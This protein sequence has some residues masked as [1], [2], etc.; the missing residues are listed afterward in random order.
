MRLY[1][2]VRAS[3]A[4]V[5]TREA[6]VHFLNDSVR[7]ICIDRPLNQE[8]LE[9]AKKAEVLFAENIIAQDAL[10][11][12]VHATNTTKTISFQ[13]IKEIVSGKKNT[14]KSVSG[15]GW[16]GAIELALTGRNSGMYEL[17]QR[18]F[19]QLPNELAVTSLGRTQQDVTA[20][21]SSHPQAIG[22]V[23]IA[24]LRNNPV[25]VKVLAVE[26]TN[27]TD[28]RYVKPNQINIYR[29]LYP[30]CYSLYLYTFASSTA[31]PAGFS[32]FVR[33]MHGQKIIQNAG[34][35]PVVIPNRVIQITT[36]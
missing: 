22:I 26:S 12:L 28:E 9:V 11:V 21:V 17:L 25:S 31:V 18:H 27:V 5:S 2:D 4:G 19:F 3:V 33:A 32:T 6:I 16:S 36:E 8:E 34:L 24:A 13:D 30:L 23:S 20:Y 7:C 10:A 29:S 1:P 14:W 15:S 35:V